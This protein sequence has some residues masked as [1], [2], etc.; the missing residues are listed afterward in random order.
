[1][2][3]FWWWAIIMPKSV[4]LPS[5][6]FENS[7]TFDNFYS[8]IFLPGVWQVPNNFSFP[9]CFGWWSFWRHVKWHLGN[10]CKLKFTSVINV[11]I[12]KVMLTSS[13][14]RLPTTKAHPGPLLASCKFLSI[15][16]IRFILISEYVMWESLR[17]KEIWYLTI[18]GKNGIVQVNWIS[19]CAVW[20]CI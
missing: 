13:R 17:I 7:E 6:S 3:G 20:C 5:S 19:F 1:M 10:S 15:E 18:W 9:C 4:T 8:L 11:K 12:T 2:F 14:C 16:V